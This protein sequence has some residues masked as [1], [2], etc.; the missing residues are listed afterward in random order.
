MNPRDL[1]P[2]RALVIGK[3]AVELMDIE[4]FLRARGWF[5]PIITEDVDNA[6][7]LLADTV[8]AFHLVIVAAPHANPQAVALIRSCVDEACPVLV[9]NGASATAQPG[10]VVLMTRPFSDADLDEALTALGLPEI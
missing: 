10:Q 8:E 3:N 7:R 9:I 4:D 6:A 2:R 5:A 1:R